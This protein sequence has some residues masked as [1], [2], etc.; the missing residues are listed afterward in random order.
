MNDPKAMCFFKHVANLCCDAHGLRGRKAAFTRKG[1]RKSFTFNELHH[2][3][4]TTVRQ[5][6]SVEDHRRVRMAQPRHRSRFPEKTIRNVGISSALMLD[7]LYC[8]GA[9]ES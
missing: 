3:E 9:F 1:L 2:D 8:D 6:S 4:V 7:D 5:V